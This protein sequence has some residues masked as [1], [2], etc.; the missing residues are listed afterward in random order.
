MLR[1]KTHVYSAWQKSLYIKKLNCSRYWLLKFFSAV[2][3]TKNH[4]VLPIQSDLHIRHKIESITFLY[5]SSVRL[6]KYLAYP[7][8]MPTDIQKTSSSIKSSQRK[9]DF[10]LLISTTFYMYLTAGSYASIHVWCINRTHNTFIGF[11][12]VL[13]SQFHLAMHN[14]HNK[15]FGVSSAMSHRRSAFFSL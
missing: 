12:Q 10:L 6:N 15:V 9:S 8:I 1:Q 3:A 14:L 5:M 4:Y 7:M 13:T 2:S 11:Y